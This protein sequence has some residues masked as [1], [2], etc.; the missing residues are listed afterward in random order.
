MQAKTKGG[1]VFG[2]AALVAMI[3]LF[4]G[5]MKK[6]GSSV[7]YADKLAGGLPTVCAGLTKHV[8]TT[9]IIVGERWSGEK[10]RAEMSKALATVQ[11]QLIKCFRVEPPQSVFDAATSMAWNFGVPKVCGSVSMKYWQAGAW[12]LGCERMSVTA[13]GKPNWSYVGGKFVRGLANRRGKETK[14]CKGD[15]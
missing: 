11:A 2:S 13:S 4:E 6:D 7:V 14:H 8:T 15:L 12:E 10:C 5:G 9:P 1:L 3:A